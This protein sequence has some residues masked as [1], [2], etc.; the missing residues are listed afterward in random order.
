MEHDTLAKL[1][2][3]MGNAEARGKIELVMMPASRVIKQMLEILK[4]ED[5]IKSYEFTGDKKTVLKIQ[6]SGAINNIGVIKPR[7]P[8]TLADYEKYE[9]RYLPA[10]DFGRLIV[11]TSQGVMTH[12]EAKAKKLGGIL[13]AF[14]Y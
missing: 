1:L 7:Y 9:S 14:V 8:I 12:I 6:L 11:S 13:L 10:K 2:S 5:Y 4:K 3:A